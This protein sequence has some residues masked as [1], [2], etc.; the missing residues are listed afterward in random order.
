MVG[1]VRHDTDLL[2]EVA[3]VEPDAFSVH[4]PSVGG[5]YDIEVPGL[6]NAYE[7]RF[8]RSIRYL[9]ESN[10]RWRDGPPDVVLRREPDVPFQILVHPF[11]Y[12]ADLAS[13]RDVLLEHLLVKCRELIAENSSGVTELEERPM[14]IDEV[15]R[16]FAARRSVDE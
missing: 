1:A 7:E 10:M 13:D 12:V 14:D 3:G 11:S 5:G 6:V 8:F 9:S 2:A 4:N 15:A 16:Y